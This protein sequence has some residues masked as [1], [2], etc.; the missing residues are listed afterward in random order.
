[1]NHRAA[2]LHGMGTDE[3]FVGYMLSAPIALADQLE[4]MYAGTYA[5][6][7]DRQGEST[8]DVQLDVESDFQI[9]YLIEM[10]QRPQLG[11]DAMAGPF[12][13]VWQYTQLW[14]SS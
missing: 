6:L 5:V 7:S 2:M 1:M 14:N 11:S 9:K 13:Q 8:K 4:V 12:S 10:L 3:A